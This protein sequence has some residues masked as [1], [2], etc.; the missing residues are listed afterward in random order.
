MKI[1]AYLALILTLCA[2]CSDSESS[3]SLNAGDALGDT[4]SE[5]DIVSDDII[6]DEGAP[7]TDLEPESDATAPEAMAL[8]SL[9]SPLVF[10]P[11]EGDPAPRIQTVV[12]LGANDTLAVAWSG[13]DQDNVLGIRFAL[14]GLDGSKTTE[15]YTLSSATTG[16]QNEPSICA[17]KE[18]GYVVAWSRDTQSTGPEGENLEIRFRLIDEEGKPLGELDS[19]V[20][21]TVP[22]NHWLAEVACA[23]DGGFVIAGVRPDTDDITFGAFV[24]RHDKDGAPQGDAIALNIA[25]EG[26]QSYPDLAVNAE[27]SIIAL[28]KDD[29]LV[30][31]GQDIE[32]VMSR[33]ILPSPA[34]P[35]AIIP[36]A[37]SAET[38]ASYGQVAANSYDNTARA[39]A[40]F[41][42]GTLGLWIVDESGPIGT[43][44]LPEGGG[45]MN[46]PALSSLQTETYAVA[47]Q[48]GSGDNAR[49]KI[50]LIDKTEVIKGPTIVEN[51]PQLPYPLS[52]DGRD[53]ALALGWTVR[54]SEDAYV[55]RVAI[56]L[57]PDK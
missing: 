55:P 52:V 31:E 6:S 29:A 44:K 35:G 18:G 17:L 5:A 42:D 49:L 20:L 14:Y 12:A 1:P 27:G 28:W 15:T 32:R 8:P 48:H 56:F 57:S 36:I 46:N 47:F 4:L 26:T 45:A 54:N 13:V 34:E 33:W 41:A 16:V 10:E 22:G 23:P 53:G 3:K 43:I 24:W 7:S 9:Q 2:S 51:G 25:P 50:A 39:A 38:A 30:E 19:R 37:G 40:T 11:G 21:S